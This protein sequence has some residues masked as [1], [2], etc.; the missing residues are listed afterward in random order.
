MAASAE[1]PSPVAAGVEGK[2]AVASSPSAV[3]RRS[4]RA[5]VV[6]RGTRR[7]LGGVKVYLL[8]HK[9]QATTDDLGEARF[10][11]VPDGPFQ[12]VVNLPGYERFELSDDGAAGDAPR[13]LR[14]TKRNY[15]VYETTVTDRDA[16]RDARTRSLKPSEFLK[17]PGAYGD[18]VK[19]VQNLPGVGRVG[20]L[21]S[22]V[23]I[24]GSAPQDTSY[25]IDGHQVPI[26]FHF[27]GLTSVVF[28][29][30]VE[31][32][33]YLASGYGPE[34]GRALGG[35][36]GVTT[37]AG[38][39]DRFHLLTFAD[40]FQAGA[41]GEGTTGGGGTWLVG[42]RQS[43][44]G[45]VLKAVLQPDK[46]YDLLVA[47]KY[48]D[49]LVVWEQKASA[50]TRVKIVGVGSYDEVKFLYDNP[51][52]RDASGRGTFSN[53]TSF[54]RLIPQVSYRPDD[55]SVLK[56]SLGVGQD[57]IRVDV[58]R[59]F[60]DV[61]ALQL[62]TRGDYDR[63]F[64]SAYRGGLGFDHAFT[65]A[66]VGYRLP[67]AGGG[68]P[69]TAANSSTNTAI[70]SVVAPAYQLYGL[71]WRNVFTL[72]DWTIEPKLRVERHQPV[73]ET[74]LLPRFAVNYRWDDS[75]KLRAAAG[76]YAQP[77]Q[78]A[79]LDGRLG[80]PD[81]SSERAGHATVG[82]EKDFRGGASRGL[83]MSA[84]FFYKDLDRLVVGTPNVRLV[85]GHL[86]PVR[87]DNSGIGHAF[88][89]ASQLK[90]EGDRWKGWLTYTLSKSVRRDPYTGDRPFRYD[91]TH[92]LNAMVSYDLGRRW[93]LGARLRLVSGQR[94]TPIVGA[95]YDADDD[96]Y[97]PIAGAANSERVPA[98]WS[99]DLRFDKQW[100]FD[101][102]L[103]SMYLDVQNAT[104]NKNVEGLR[105]SY[106]YSQSEWVQGL[107]MIPVF[108]LK[109]EF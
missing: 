62:T 69:G 76:L 55:A 41:L 78:A 65:W 35:L 64:S 30:A 108:G 95:V 51:I 67:G 47:P 104:N 23:I 42:A 19:A 87:F 31:R 89:L 48:T 39:D 79:E 70:A 24:E 106:D 61:T 75:L 54:W 8:P 36:V 94:Y 88:G 49:A 98:F 15:E 20:A 103:L 28:P 68:G 18:P 14:V 84:D 109:A 52:G 4:Y 6:E 56:L 29:E 40:T 50:K 12:W 37:R 46:N 101:G 77:P 59:D 100:V 10:D 26:I 38:R 71:Y 21:S 81:I 9:L 32:V 22:A 3:A 99:L 60:F 13:T 86:E 63:K 66:D 93:S 107:P 27:G 1:T 72:G 16:N 105:Y 25:L 96:V 53:T 34:Y 43:Y 7:A 58:Y 90:Y 44:I 5:R 85:N 73:D 45:T 17:A 80:N 97:R 102:W 11:D 2:L 83:T 57:R 33:D 91:Q 92:I 74:F 82:F